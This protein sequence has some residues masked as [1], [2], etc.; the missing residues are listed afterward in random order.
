MVELNCMGEG[1]NKTTV[2]YTLHLQVVT[3]GLVNKCN[4]L[5]FTICVNTQKQYVHMSKVGECLGVQYQY[6][7]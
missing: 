6:L 3:K 2:Q 7:V 4:L 1:A 5:H